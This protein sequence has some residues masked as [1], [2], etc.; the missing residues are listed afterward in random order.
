M[1]INHNPF[2]DHSKY[3]L[4][5]LKEVADYL[6]D[7][8]LSKIQQAYFL[9]DAAHSG[10]FRRSGQPYISHPVSVAMILAQ[11]KMDCET[12]VSGLLH[13]VLEDTPTTKGHYP[14]KV[15]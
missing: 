15:W 14:T 2:E 13:D 11:M 7:E 4:E 10:Q 1:M 8:D 9:A 3:S 12:I 6:S 5:S